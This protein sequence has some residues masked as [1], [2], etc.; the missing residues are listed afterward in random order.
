[1]EKI[2]VVED[3]Q[4]LGRMYEKKFVNLGYSV[5]LAVNGEEGV[6]FMTDYKPDIVL[7]DLKM[8]V[9]DGYGF[10]EKVRANQELK[11]IPIIVI[12]NLSQPED[13][14]KLMKNGVADYFEKTATTPKEL[15]EKIRYILDE[16]KKHLA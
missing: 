11:H 5:K 1:M 15:A 12:T 6:R 3:E 8:P 2:L 7:L 16:Q 10:L 13:K 9:L 14:A 4:F